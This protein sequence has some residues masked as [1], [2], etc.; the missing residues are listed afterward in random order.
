MNVLFIHSNSLEYKAKQK[1]KMAEAVSKDLM[2]K[3]AGECLVCFMAFEEADNGKE[4]AVS[5]G[6]VKEIESVSSQLGVKTV[7]LYPFVHLLF[8]KKPSE[9]KTALRIMNE[10]QKQLEKKFTVVKSPFGWYKSFKL[11]CKGHPLAELSREILGEGKAAEGK[12]VSKAVQAEE[13][14]RSEWF[15]LD[16][17]G[18][19]HALKKG[20][21]KI[22]GFDFK[23]WPN[24]EK[25]A[26]YEI[27][28]SREVREEPPHVKLMKQ[29]ELA[30]YEPGSDP[31]NL[32]YPPKGKLVKKLVE[33]FVTAKMIEYGAMEIE[34]PIMY[35]YEHP[36]LKDY[37]NRFPAR[38]Y[39]IETP[40]KKV[41]LRFSACFGQFL[42]LHDAVVSYKHLPLKVYELTRYSFRVEKRGE[43]TGLRRLRAFTM[44]DCHAFCADLKQAKKEFV[45]RFELGR[46]IQ[47][48]LGL[49]E[50]DLELAVRAVKPFW[51][52]NEKFILEW[53]KKWKKPV[54][55]EMWGEQFFYFILKYELNFVDA[56][57]KASALTTDQIDVENAKRYG[58]S[59]IGADNKKKFP[60]ILHLSPSGAVE[61]VLYSLL[62]KAFMDKKGKGRGKFPLWLSPVQARVASV[63]DKFTEFA[64]KTAETLEKHC[65]RADVDDRDESIG[66]KIR[67]AE[68]EW[69]PFILVVGE[70]EKKT[71]KFTVRF[72]STGKQKEMG[73][74]ELVKLIQKECR[75]KPF[76]PLPLPMRLSRRPVFIQQQ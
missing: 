76:H 21:G 11:E 33:E 30:D 26:E 64:E 74:K 49:N 35:D 23:K 54:L 31:G 14:L 53:V 28:K 24:L 48:E 16:E 34:A 17:K 5:K 47:E 43:L 75:G 10:T 22:G 25:F 40:N 15:V 66:K 73:L 52:E 6:L 61:R 69:V 27:S 44:P 13:K 18:K 19:L 12:E 60:L 70:K 8:G 56:L 37:L 9:T 36:A 46:K 71:R 7:A 57:G 55:V 38:Q 3:R 67:Q 68:L 62:E 50:N 4:L 29:L 59:F 41:F 72:R 65:I 20:K 2:E 63:S 51:K 1:T 32:R 58:L 42:M 45:K 39:T